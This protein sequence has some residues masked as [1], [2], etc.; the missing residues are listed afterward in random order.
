M[1]QSS[2]VIFTDMDGTL[3]DHHTYS[4]AAAQ[5]T[6]DALAARGIPVIPNTSKTF[7][8]MT[9]LRQKIGLNGPFVVET[10]QRL[11]FHTAFLNK[12]RPV[13]SGRTVFGVSRLFRQRAT[14]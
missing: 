3:L 12:N 9:E 10:A 1:D 5:P 4:F 14:G 11:I 8:E 2:T 6:L 7:A 13:P